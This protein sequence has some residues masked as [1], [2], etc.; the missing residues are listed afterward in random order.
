MDDRDLVIHAFPIWNH[1]G[2]SELTIGC[3]KTRCGYITS[4][5]VSSDWN[6]VNCEGCKKRGRWLRFPPLSSAVG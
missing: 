5:V 4:G 1:A 3:S 6:E 2:P